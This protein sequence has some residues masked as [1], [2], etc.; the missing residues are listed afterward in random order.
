MCRATDQGWY[1]F[2]MTSGGYWRIWLY[3]GGT[4]Y[5]LLNNGATTAINLKNQPNIVGAK[6][7]GSELTFLIN[8]IE[9]GSAVD[10]TFLGGGQ[11]GV[12]I[13]AEYP[14]LGVEF[15]YFSA[16]VPQ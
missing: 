6:C 13:F 3:T 16:A 12:S 1:E 4:N 14:D 7:V 2:S 15:D 10:R 8:G 9:V 11:V 5:Q